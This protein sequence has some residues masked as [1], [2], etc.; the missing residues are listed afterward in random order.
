MGFPFD[1]PKV[2]TK[3]DG[4]NWRRWASPNVCFGLHATFTEV[5]VHTARF[6]PTQD[7]SPGSHKQFPAIG[8]D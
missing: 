6:D 2:H 4:A 8:M 3:H 7:Q 5:S 1:P